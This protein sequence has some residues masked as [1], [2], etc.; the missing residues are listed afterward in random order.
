VL[1]LGIIRQ[2]FRVS[3]PSGEP[4]E[5]A[6]VFVDVRLV[7]LPG[8]MGGVAA[9]GAVA[10]GMAGVER[11]RRIA[12][13]DVGVGSTFPEEQGGPG[14]FDLL[15]ARGW[16]AQLAGEPLGARGVLPNPVPALIE[17]LRAVGVAGDGDAG[18]EAIGEGDAREGHTY[19][20]R[21]GASHEPQR[22]HPVIGAV[23]ANSSP[24]RLVRDHATVS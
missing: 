10:F 20:V 14:S 9:L 3:S 11:L 17:V 5:L 24:P 8:E 4:V 6:D 15:P 16:E 22:A 21:I 19:G 12:L 2:V 7:R 23:S 1:G 13:G 18:P